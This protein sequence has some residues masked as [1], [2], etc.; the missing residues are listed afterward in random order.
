MG[1]IKGL[2]TEMGYDS[3]KRYLEELKLKLERDKQRS[4]HAV[5]NE[6]KGERY[7]ATTKENR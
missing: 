1:K 2:V 5:S 3:A 7:E 6:E 4:K